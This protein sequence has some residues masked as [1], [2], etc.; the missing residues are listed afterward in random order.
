MD[1]ILFYLLPWVSIFI[2]LLGII[3]SFKYNRNYVVPF[4]VCIT[5]IVVYFF[6]LYASTGFEGMG[7][8][9]WGMGIFLLGV[10]MIFFIWL[11]G[12]NNRV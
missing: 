4:I 1:H 7:V 9:F 12:K 5:G 2:F 3:L 6:G 10:V 11:M 8:S